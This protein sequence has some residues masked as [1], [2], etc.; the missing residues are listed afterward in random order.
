MAITEGSIEGVLY[1]GLG[2]N[3]EWKHKELKTTF[4]MAPGLGQ[5]IMLRSD[6]ECML[7]DILVEL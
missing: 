4:W 1:L 2:G 5:V 6:T 3:H 7:Q